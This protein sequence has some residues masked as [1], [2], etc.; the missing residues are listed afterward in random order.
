[1]EPER[2][3]TSIP[4]RTTDGQLCRID[5]ISEGAQ[6][7]LAVDGGTVAWLTPRSGDAVASRLL[8]TFA[9]LTEVPCRVGEDHSRS[10]IRVAVFGDLATLGI[11]GDE[12]VKLLQRR[13]VALG[14][15]LLWA[16]DRATYGEA[17]S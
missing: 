14:W 15:L 4:C 3:R 7:T 10:S 12:P 9:P 13:A 11:G 16:G 5:V 1:M 2:T 6:F 17:A 8:K